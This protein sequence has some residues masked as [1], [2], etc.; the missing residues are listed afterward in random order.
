[1]T[2]V[3]FR[4]GLKER[5]E[6]DAVTAADAR[7][8]AEALRPLLSDRASWTS[9]VAAEWCRAVQSASDDR[10]SKG[11]HVFA[12]DGGAHIGDEK[13]AG[14]PATPRK[15]TSPLEVMRA[16]WTYGALSQT[17][18]F[19][20][21]GDNV[22]FVTFSANVPLGPAQVDSDKTEQV[23]ACWL[24]ITGLERYAPPTSDGARILLEGSAS[25]SLSPSADG[26][27]RSEGVWES[28]GEVRAY[29]RQTLAPNVQHTVGLH[30]KNPSGL[31]HEPP[32]VA[33]QADGSVRIK[34]FL[35]SMQVAGGGDALGLAP[36]C[37]D[38]ATISP[39][40]VYPGTT[41]LLTVSFSTT[42]SL[43]GDAKHSLRLMLSGLTD[44]LTPDSEALSLRPEPESS[45][46]VLAVTGKWR[47]EGGILEVPLL[48]P[49]APGVVYSFSFSLCNPAAAKPVAGAYIAVGGPAAVAVAGAQ[50][51]VVEALAASRGAAAPGSEALVLSGTLGETLGEVD[52]GWYTS[53]SGHLRHMYPHCYK[54]R[55]EQ[56]PTSTAPCLSK[57]MCLMRP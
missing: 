5:I 28:G 18:P 43:P 37:F 20:S 29:L 46:A 32:Q 57:R 10:P 26:E 25:R 47:R 2:E 23:I 1:M 33:I 6:N 40:S 11:W 50:L 15:M 49:T 31:S 54:S 44:S 7:A 22:I 19:F 53:F 41:N 56:V 12:A 30:V 34:S 51:K 9:T 38:V 14:A 55:E 8:L 35:L 3:V 17:S 4:A 13:N 42:V 45:A 48:S 16:E 52:R 27:T 24:Q 39:S 36:P 21:G